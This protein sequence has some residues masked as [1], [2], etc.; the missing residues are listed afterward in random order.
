MLR[1]QPGEVAERLVGTYRLIAVVRS[2]S[3]DEYHAGHLPAFFYPWQC[4]C[5]GQTEGVGLHDDVAFHCLGGVQSHGGAVGLYGRGDE[6]DGVHPSVSVE[7]QEQ[8]QGSGTE[9]HVPIIE[10]YSLCLLLSPGRG[11]LQ[12]SV[13][14]FQLAMEIIEQRGAELTL[15]LVIQGGIDAVALSGNEILVNSFCAF[16]VVYLRPC[17]HRTAEKQE[18]QC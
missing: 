10:H 9:S 14:C 13:L 1:E 16:L 7:R 8:P 5:A 15:R 4:Q 18:K 12:C 3:V 11:G 17:H 2:R 6:A